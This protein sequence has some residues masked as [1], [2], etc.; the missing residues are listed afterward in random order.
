MRACLSVNQDWQWLF[1]GSDL[2]QWVGL[3]RADIPSDSWE[4]AGDT[5][6]KIPV[7]AENFGGDLRT[8]ERFQNFELCFEFKLTQ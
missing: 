1:D 5:L 8:K 2:D 6:H 3:G 7:S 4:I